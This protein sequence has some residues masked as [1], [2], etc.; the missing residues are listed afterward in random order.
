[1]ILCVSCCCEFAISSCT[2]DLFSLDGAY[3]NLFAS[4][5]RKTLVCVL[6]QF[7][8]GLPA[9]MLAATAKATRMAGTAI[10]A[11]KLIS[12]AVATTVTTAAHQHTPCTLN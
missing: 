8:L 2:N 11:A 3:D 10:P 4:D 12:T 6:V 1:M 5:L 9:M 7:F